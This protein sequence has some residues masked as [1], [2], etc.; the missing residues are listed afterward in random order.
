MP[1]TNILWLDLETTGLDPERDLILELGLV[2]TDGLE[3]ILDE[4]SIVIDRGAVALPT[5]VLNMHLDSGL[6]LDIALRGVTVP[7]AARKAHAVLS[8]WWPTAPGTIVVGGSGIDRF[9]IPFLRRCEHLYGIAERFNYGTLD[10]SGIKRISRLAG[11]ELQAGQNGATH[12]A[13]DDARDSFYMA[14]RLASLLEVG[15]GVTA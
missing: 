2:I 3:R 12:R 6:M 11:R 15:P 8:N 7:E 10:T 4:E 9:D 5:D 13:V 14:Q 1:N